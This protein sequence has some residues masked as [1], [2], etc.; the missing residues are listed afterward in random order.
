LDDLA[1][2]VRGRSVGNRYAGS[3]ASQTLL[4]AINACSQSLPH[5]NKTSKRARSTGESMQHHFGIPSFFMT[6]TFDDENSLLVQILHGTEIDTDVSLS[7][8]TD[9]D[10]AARCSQ[11]RE[12][13]IAYP[14]LAALNFDMLLNIL[15][16]EVV[17]WSI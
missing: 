2:A 10:L 5:T 9:N 14:G 4:N 17:G 6:A 15:V 8:L 12:L 13:R 11:R 3:K 7:E 1:T 16:E